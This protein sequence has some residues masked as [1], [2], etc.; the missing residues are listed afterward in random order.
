VVSIWCRKKIGKA[1]VIERLVWS[2]LLV[3]PEEKEPW[4]EVDSVNL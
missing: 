2:L 1:G 3:L 4:R